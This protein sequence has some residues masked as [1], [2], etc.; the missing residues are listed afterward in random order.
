M[1]KAGGAHLEFEVLLVAVEVVLDVLAQR[2]AVFYP[3]AVG[4][5]DFHDD[6]V[7]LAD[8]DIDQEIVLSLQPLVDQ[9][10]DNAFLYHF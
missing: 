9:C 10:L 4:M 8:F 3:Y 6:F 7:V 5:V 1:S 2:H